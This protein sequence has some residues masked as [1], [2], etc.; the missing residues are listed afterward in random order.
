MGHGKFISAN[1]RYALGFFN[2]SSNKALEA[3]KCDIKN[4]PDCRLPE[5]HHEVTIYARNSESFADPSQRLPP[6]CVIFDYTEL[7]PLEKRV[8]WQWNPNQVT[9][10]FT[11]SASE[12]TYLFWRSDHANYDCGVDFK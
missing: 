12:T 10:S 11:S 7:E 3:P 5:N 4:N 8:P 2:H 1:T 6:N 9:N